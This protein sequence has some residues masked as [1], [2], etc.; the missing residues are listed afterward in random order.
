[1]SIRARA[2]ATAVLLSGLTAVHAADWPHW[3]GPGANGVAPDST[4]PLRWS[5]TENVAWKSKL[6]GVGVSTPIVS[7]NRV[8]VTSQIGSGV[9]REG[10]HPRLVQGGDAAAQ[11]ERAIAAAASDK[12][13]FVVEAF[14]THRRQARVGAPARGGGHADAGAR[15]AQPRDAEP[16]QRRHD[17]V[18]AVRHRSAGGARAGRQGRLAASPRRRRSRR[19]TSSGA[20][21]SSP[22]LYRDSLILLCDHASASYLLALDKRT[23]KE[24]WRADRGKGRSSYSTPLIVE[25]PAASS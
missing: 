23:G 12:T 20:T 17:G 7:G 1:M 19:S 18:R 4:L 11:G 5:A 24:R 6:A 2:F 13:I 8:Y 25:A 22:V 21:G 16:G 10:N 9:R 15:Q 14:S 3:R